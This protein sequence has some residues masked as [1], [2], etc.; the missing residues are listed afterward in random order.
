MSNQIPLSEILSKISEELRKADDSAKKNGSAT[1]EF[2]ECEI[3]LAVKAEKN[4]SGG[5]KVWVL[6]LESGVKKSDSNTIKLKFKKI[7]GTAHQASSTPEEPGPKIDR[8]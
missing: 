8:K 6:N 4:S 7:E 5:I 1:M 3:E 2:E